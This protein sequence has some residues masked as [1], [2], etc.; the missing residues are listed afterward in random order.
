VTKRPRGDTEGIDR[1]RA[2]WRK[3]EE[4]AH[5][6]RPSEDAD[7]DAKADKRR[8]DEALDSVDQIR[9]EAPTDLEARRG[10]DQLEREIK[11]SRTRR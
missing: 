7:E 2:D 3:G 11:R 8:E 4:T 9:A 6:A 10:A 5:H 1:L